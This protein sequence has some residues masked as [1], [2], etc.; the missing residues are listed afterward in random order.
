MKLVVKEPSEKRKSRQ[1]FPTPTKTL[2]RTGI[3]N[4]H[5]RGRKKQ[6]IVCRS[7]H[8]VRIESPLKSHRFKLLLKSDTNWQEMRTASRYRC[9]ILRS[10]ATWWNWKIFQLV[11][12][13]KESNQKSITDRH[14]TSGVANTWLVCLICSGVNMEYESL[15]IPFQYCFTA[16]NMGLLRWKKDWPLHH[17]LVE[18]EFPQ[19]NLA[20]WS[21]TKG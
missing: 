6:D 4:N 13:K 15:S 18:R 20:G 17:A 16:N 19:I 9:K 3:S 1:L 7:A 5:E 2:T 14:T 11:Y 12:L 10:G 21:S 8:N